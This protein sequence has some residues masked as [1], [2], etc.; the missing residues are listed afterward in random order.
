[1]E[2][3]RGLRKK[4]PK[5]IKS[6]RAKGRYKLDRANVKRAGQVQKMRDPTKKYE[7]EKTGIKTH[8]V[9]SRSLV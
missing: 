7:G 8:V 3:N 5:N 1:M 6:G 9:K 2:A 4:R